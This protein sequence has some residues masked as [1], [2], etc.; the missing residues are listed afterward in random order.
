MNLSNELSSESISNYK[1]EISQIFNKFKDV[2]RYN[3]NLERQYIKKHFEGK[4]D[5]DVSNSLQ[6][7]LEDYVA[8]NYE[9]KWKLWKKESEYYDNKLR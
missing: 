3:L 9:E 5:S 1:E 8:S 7:T 2:D 4:E 6:R